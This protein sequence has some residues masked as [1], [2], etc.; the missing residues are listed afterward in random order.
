MTGQINVNK[1]A[2][3]TGNTITIES[4]DKISGAA[5]SIVAPGQVIQ[6]VQNKLEDVARIATSSSSFVAT[7][8][9][10]TITPTSTSSKVLIMMT[11]SANNN[12]TNNTGMPITIYRNGS[13]NLSGAGD[14][15]TEVETRGARS[16]M[17]VS[18]QVLDS[19]AT[20]SATTYTMYTRSNSGS[21]VELP[22]SN[23]H[24]TAVVILQEIAG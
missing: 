13:V 23:N 10:G 4:G 20:T 22:Y 6:T 19:P 3:R 9:T 11:T 14:G 18:I 1:I 15:F 16:H 2:A 21:T 5:G 7:N 8:V 24:E 12:N 17:P